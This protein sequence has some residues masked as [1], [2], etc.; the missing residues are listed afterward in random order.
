[1]KDPRVGIQFKKPHDDVAV[2]EKYVELARVFPKIP[3]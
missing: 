3:L 1:M 2:G